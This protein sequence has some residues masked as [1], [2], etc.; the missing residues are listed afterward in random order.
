TVATFIYN[1]CCYLVGGNQDTLA[2]PDLN[3]V[4]NGRYTHR[5]VTGRFRSCRPTMRTD[6]PVAVASEGK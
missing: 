5:G 4:A 3:G 2:Y 1:L 6:T